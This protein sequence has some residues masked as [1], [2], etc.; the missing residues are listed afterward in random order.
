MLRIL[1]II[2]R[3]MPPK[4]VTERITVV[5]SL[6]AIIISGTWF[7]WNAI[8]T[9]LNN[10]I[11]N[12]YTYE[13]NF[14]EKYAAQISQ[15]SNDQ[16]SL[17]EEVLYAQ[18][19]YF[20]THIPDDLIIKT[21]SNDLNCN[22]LNVRE[23]VMQLELL[24]GIL[25]H[26]QTIALRDEVSSISSRSDLFDN[27]ALTDLA[28]GYRSIVRCAEST[29]CDPETIAMTF[30]REM[31][32]FTNAICNQKFVLAGGL[33]AELQQIAKFLNQTIKFHKIYWKNDKK[34]NKLFFCSRYN[35]L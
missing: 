18:C 19:K 30:A 23:K 34:R 1:T 16:Q 5:I 14:R 20:Y 6:I 35:D 21:I 31:T 4:H 27:N 8:S 13:E 25:S 17:L 22:K 15:F 32:S 10:T 29:R 26:D 7:A 9:K 24:R 12:A 33:E 28:V 3:H 11:E 2:S